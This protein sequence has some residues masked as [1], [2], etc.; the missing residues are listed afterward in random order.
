ML[1]SDFHAI[2]ETI[3]KSNRMTPL[4]SD[5][6]VNNQHRYILKQW[7]ALMVRADW[8]VKLRISC[9]IYL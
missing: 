6:R 1:Y 4:M 2:E 5:N 3:I 8:L 9:A 7:I